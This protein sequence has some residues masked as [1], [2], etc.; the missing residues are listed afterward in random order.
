LELGFNVVAIEA[1]PNLYQF[2]LESF[3]KEIYEKRI[4]LI[5]AAV[6]SRQRNLSQA[7]ISFYPHSKNTLWGSVD[8][9][10][11]YRNTAIHKSPH[12]PEITINTISL[13][14]LVERYGCPI[15]LKVDI[16]GMDAE[17]VEDLDRIPVLPEFISWET[18]KRSLFRV[19]YTHMRLFGLGYRRFRVTQQMYS[20]HDSAAQSSG[21]IPSH[22]PSQ[23]RGIL[24]AMLTHIIL[25]VIYK[26]IGPRSV[27]SWAENH[28][29]S[30]INTLPR[31]LRK[32]MSRRSIPFPGW[33]DSH[34]ALPKK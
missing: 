6:V 17:V 7:K 31:Y 29:I 9:D 5:N 2:G 1:D 20:L 24:S 15:F 33:F 27:F 22:H 34:A 11:V 30:I 21:P 26:I 10:F 19:L 16:E 3:S 28:T 12:D 4:T 18:G 25:F 14:E 8:I 13:E 32:E 23:W